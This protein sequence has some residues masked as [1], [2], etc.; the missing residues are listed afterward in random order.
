MFLLRENVLFKN[1]RYWP[2][3]KATLEIVLWSRFADEVVDAARNDYVL[4]GKTV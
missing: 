3:R 1:R 4:N 2:V